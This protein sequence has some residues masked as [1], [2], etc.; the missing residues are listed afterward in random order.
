MNRKQWPGSAGG[1][2][3]F[4]ILGAVQAQVGKDEVQIPAAQQRVILASLLLHNNRV[5]SIDRIAYFLWGE[6]LPPSAVATIR[7]YVMRLR[8]TL[9][10]V[11]SERII[12]RAPGYMIELTNEESDLCSFLELRGKAAELAAASRVA[13]ASATLSAGLNL[14]R[15][16]P[17]MDIPSS[18]LHDGEVPPLVELHMQTMEWWIDLELQLGRHAQLTPQLSHLTRAHPL[19][20]SLT[21][22]LMLALHGAG[23]QSDALA[24]FLHT[25]NLLIE[26]LGTEPG[27]ELCSVQ[28]QI[29]T[30]NGGDTAEHRRPVPQ[31]AAEPREPHSW[32]SPLPMAVGY[33]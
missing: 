29:L 19:R 16:E 4:R 21:A 11:A 12:T 13:E 2:L 30:G 31:S 5:V 26:Q 33:S 22:R 23:R 10:E 27:R 7:T 8:R 3:H 1:R 15:D 20:E 25:R 28:H 24:A 32:M 14:W 6:N 18:P 9:G 17:L